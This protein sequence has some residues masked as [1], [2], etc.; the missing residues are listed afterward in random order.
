VVTYTIGHAVGVASASEEQLSDGEGPHRS[1]GD[2]GVL[3]Q[4]H[5][6]HTVTTARRPPQQSLQ[7]STAHAT[8]TTN[9]VRTYTNVGAVVKQ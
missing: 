9:T 2:E 6:H 5:A 8:H 7:Y 1:G 3:T 4:L